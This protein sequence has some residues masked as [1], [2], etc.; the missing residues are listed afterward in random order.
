[1]VSW[2]IPPP[3]S[4]VYGSQFTVVA[5]S[6]SSGT[7]TYSTSGGCTNVAGLVTMNSSTTACLVS[8]SVAAAGNYGIGSVGP[9]S[10]SA[11]GPV[12]TV[13]PSSINFGAVALDSI[14]TKTVTVSNTGSATATISSPRISLLKA[15]NS[16]EFVMINLCPSS[17]AAGKSCTITITFVAG[18]YYNTPQTATLEVMDNAP[19]S[20]Q[21]VALSAT[22]LEPQTITFTS[23]PSSSVYNSSFPVA[24]T[25]GGSGN[26][27][28]FTA[29]GACS[30]PPGSATYTMTSGSG[31]CSVIANQAGNSTYAA[32]AQVTKTVTATL[33]AQ[34]ITLHERSVVRGVQEHLHGGRHGLERARG[35][36]HKFR[37]VHQFWR[38]LHHD[39]EHRN[40]LG[41]RQPSR[42]L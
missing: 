35:D 8:A 2:S 18:A 10:V 42:Q 20:P 31:T 26:P 38:N 27:V 24:A 23:V 12:I 4:A 39:Q 30:V 25:G 22:V 11:S 33:A 34:T 29:S 28:T 9:T 16:D 17:F 40:L 32:A 21:P 13:S 1:M 3:L 19:G 41:D 36:L 14:T 15:G 6:N 37:V 7:I 5:T